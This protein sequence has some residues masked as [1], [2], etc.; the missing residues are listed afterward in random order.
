MVYIILKACPLHKA[1]RWMA[2]VERD[3]GQSAD[4][5]SNI[6]KKNFT[7]K[8]FPPRYLLYSF[9]HE[10]KGRGKLLTGVQLK[11]HNIRRP[12][13]F[14]WRVI[15]CVCKIINI[16]IELLR[17]I[18]SSIGAFYILGNNQDDHPTNQPATN[19]ATNRRTRGF[20]EK[21]HFL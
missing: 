3:S 17:I 8:N 10:E 12:L 19:Q 14:H 16:G 1:A 7:N 4:H 5:F 18:N 15:K 9:H 11:T 2:G 20:I 21:L 13:S 6:T